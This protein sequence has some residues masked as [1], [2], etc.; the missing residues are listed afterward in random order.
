MPG[1]VAKIR[2]QTI[3]VCVCCLGDAAKRDRRGDEARVRAVV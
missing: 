2:H 3:C 1:P